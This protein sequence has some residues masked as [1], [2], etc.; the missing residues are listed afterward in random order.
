MKA[1]IDR[2]EDSKHAVLIVGDEEEQKV[3]PAEELPDGAQEGTWL[4]VDFDGGTVASI[5]IDE[6]ETEKRQRRISSKMEK[7]K[8]RKGKK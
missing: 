1:V 6:E 5:S 7:L 4:Q 8:E 3:I 2:I